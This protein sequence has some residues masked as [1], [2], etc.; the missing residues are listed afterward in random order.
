[1]VGNSD[2][3]SFPRYPK[4]VLIREQHMTSD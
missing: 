1:M 2:G 4:S 3:A